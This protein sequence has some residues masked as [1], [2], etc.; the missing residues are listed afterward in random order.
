MMPFQPGS[1]SVGLHPI[2]PAVAESQVEQLL[3]Q[4]DA[5]E[6]AGFDGVTVSEHH[7][8]FPG[9]LPQPVLAVNWILAAVSRIWAAPAPVLLGIRSPR[10]LAEELAWTSSRFPGRVGA[11][12][13]AGYAGSDFAAVGLSTGDRTAFADL[14]DQLLD[15][16]SV[17]GPLADDSAIAQR[18]FEAHHLLVAAKSLTAV[19]RAASAGCGVLFPGGEPAD[20]LATLSKAYRD[21]GGLGPIVGIAVVWTGD[22]TATTQLLDA[23][24]ARAAQPDTQQASGFRRGLFTGSPLH[25]ADELVEYRSIAGL[26]SLNL[27]FRADAASEADVYRQIEWAGEVLLPELR[28]ESP[29]VGGAVSE[30]RGRPT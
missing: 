16:L 8:G 29:L 23:H 5:A 10:L 30:R 12:V 14:L 9:Y 2:A 22:E 1:V 25:I 21:S 15:A 13:A 27:R 11:A 19:R 24:Y 18:A 3:L 7:V 6:R 20:R 17:D 26:T 28:R 4:A